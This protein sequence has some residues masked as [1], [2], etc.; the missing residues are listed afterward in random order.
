MVL[1]GDGSR[2]PFGVKMLQFSILSTKRLSV[3]VSHQSL[4]VSPASPRHVINVSFALSGTV[5][6]FWVLNLPPDFS[7]FKRLRT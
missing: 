1:P 2:A 4:P 6:G 5:T 7:I 3:F